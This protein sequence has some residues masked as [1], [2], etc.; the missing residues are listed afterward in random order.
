M[1]DW[2]STTEHE[3]FTME[4]QHLN[5]FHQLFTDLAVEADRELKE[6]LE[7]EETHRGDEADR[8]QNEQ[9]NSMRLKLIA[10]TRLFKQKIDNS[11]KRINEGSFGECLD[12]GTQIGLSRLMARPTAELCIH[13][14]EEQEEG[15]RHIRYEKRSHTLG[16]SIVGDNVLSF[17]NGDELTR[18]PTPK[19]LIQEGRI[20]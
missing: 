7:L 9:N 16:K 3:E 6:A 20:S 15:E 14:K 2:S 19:E 4:K 8:W 13:C 18:V 10:R 11:L 1:E 12:C 17:Q 5:H